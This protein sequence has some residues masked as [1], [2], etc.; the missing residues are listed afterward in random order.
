MIGEPFR[1]GTPCM[2]VYP[3][4]EVAIFDFNLLSKQLMPQSHRQTDPTPTPNRSNDAWPFPVMEFCAICCRSDVDFLGVTSVF[5]ETEACASQRGKQA[6]S[7][8]K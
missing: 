5:D 8:F 6:K 2:H 3:G 1:V 4:S 7:W